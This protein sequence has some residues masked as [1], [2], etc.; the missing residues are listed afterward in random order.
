MDATGGKP[1]D[2]ILCMGCT[3]LPY[4]NTQLRCQ[5]ETTVPEAKSSLLV[6]R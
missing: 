3:A 4:Q 1:I 2:V 6:Q 5:G